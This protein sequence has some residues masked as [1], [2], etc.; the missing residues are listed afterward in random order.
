MRIDVHAHYFHPEY[1][2]AEAHEKIVADI[3]GNR[4]V[5]TRNDLDLIVRKTIRW[6]V[7]ELEARP[8]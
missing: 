4:T 6:G 5:A 7:G 1:I 8:T 2:E 3:Q